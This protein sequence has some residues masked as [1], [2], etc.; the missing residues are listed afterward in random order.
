MSD[1]VQT[2]KLGDFELQS[3]EVLKDA[4]IAYRTFG[5]PNLPAVIYPTWYSGSMDSS[6]VV[7]YHHLTLATR[8]RGQ[9]LARLEIHDF[10]A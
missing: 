5:D 1:E 9:Y 2:Y 8:D 3:G 4:F 10:V 7:Q 6:D